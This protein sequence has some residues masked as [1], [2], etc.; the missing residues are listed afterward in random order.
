MAF[1]VVDNNI[2]EAH[3]DGSN[4][5]VI[6]SN[7]LSIIDGNKNKY[8]FVEFKDVQFSLS[9]SPNSKLSKIGEY[10]FSYCQ[11]LTSIDF[12]NAKS[13]QSI[14][15]FAFQHCISLK[16]LHFHSSLES[17]SEYG[18]FADCRNIDEITFPDDSNIKTIAAGVF[19]GTKITHFRVPA[20]CTSIN[21]EKFVRTNVEKFTVQEDNIAYKEYDGSIF[22]FDLTTLIVHRKT[23]QLSLPPQTTAL[24]YIALSNL[25]ADISIRKTITSF[26][27]LSFYDYQGKKISIY[28]VFD[29]V[30][31]RMFE[32]CDNLIEVKFKNE[33][34]TIE[35]NSFRHCYKLR[36][37][38]FIHP[39]KSIV[40]NAFPD[41]QKI[42]FYGQV[43]S[44][45]EQITDV[46]INECRIFDTYFNKQRNYIST[47]NL[48]IIILLV[49]S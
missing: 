10:A 14:G 6:P 4:S 11:K 30:S 45:R 23:G 9:F 48:P 17:L 37:I 26:S 39:V 49:Y 19:A 7:I 3:P 16:S 20:S 46:H 13:L 8:P 38:L 29:R 43:S 2:V 36:R 28:G 22:S 44:I 27:D 32:W 34:N 41:I 25:K 47:N 21:G 42:C 31:A 1:D 12:S 33:V 15:Y 5:I 40:K 18:A 24:G 35:T